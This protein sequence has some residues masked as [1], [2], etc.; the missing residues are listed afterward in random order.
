MTTF[1]APV[2]AHGAASRQ[3]WGERLNRLFD[4]CNRCTLPLAGRRV[5]SFHVC[6]W[7]GMAVAWTLAFWLVQARGLALEVMSLVAL[8]GTVTFV[9]LAMLT[10]I[11]GGEEELIYYHHEIAVLAVAALLLQ[12]LG[13]PTLPYLDVTILAV[14]GFLTFGRVGCFMV[15]CCN[16]QPCPIGVC[17]RHE[18]AEAGFPRYLVGTRFLPIQL[19]E[20]VT[21]SLIVTIGV[22]LWVR[23]CAPGA[24]LVW[25][26]V[27]YGA[28]RFLFEYFRGD[29]SRPYLGALSEG[30]WTTVVILALVVVGGRAGRLPVEPWHLWVCG[31]VFVAA[32]VSLARGGRERR[33]FRVRHLCEIARL[34]DVATEEARSVGV[35]HTG[36]TSLGVL[37]SAHTVREGGRDVQLWSLS[38]P[39][40]DL[41][42]GTLERLVATVAR[43]KGVAGAPWKLGSGVYHLIL[44]APGGARAL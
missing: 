20:S 11:I 32:A 9:V 26:S 42:A 16:G 4:R 2:S 28:L 10:K 38:V 43:L 15:G 13:Q 39:R 29:P 12:V 1:A 5:S 8:S 6:G 33:L 37:V 34:V 35:S 19:I 30:Q 17:Y 40:L 14:G 7:I 18:H 44:P 22:A 3:G 23:G 24:V 25:Y 21:V 41:P 36:T 31:G 27:A